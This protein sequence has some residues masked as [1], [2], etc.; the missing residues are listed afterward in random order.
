MEFTDGYVR[1]LKPQAQRYSEWDTAGDPRGLGV[2]VTPN[3]VKSYVLQAMTRPGG[4]Q[5]L[6]TLGR[7]GSMRLPAARKA[8]WAALEQLQAGKDP[9]REKQT[10]GA[11]TFGALAEMYIADEL[12][13][14]RQG[15]TVETY[16]RRDWLGETPFRARVTTHG[17][18]EWITEWKPGRDRQFSDLP[19]ASITREDILDRLNVIRRERG[20]YAARHALAAIRQVLNWAAA[21]YRAGV[22]VSPAAGLR[23]RVV[24]L[25]GAALMR[26]RVLTADEIRAIW[27]ACPRMGSFGVLVR[28]LLLTCARRDDWAAASWK[29]LSG[30]EG[31][32][33]MLTVPPARYKTAQTHEVM[34]TP[35][36]VSALAELPRFQGCDWLFS[37]DGKRPLQ[38]FS[39]S[40]RRL[41]EASGVTGWR[42]HDLRRTGR[43][44]MANIGV[45]DAAAE[46]VLGHSLGSLNATYNMSKH[47]A[48]K[49]AA[50][51]ALEAEI[52]RIV[53]P[54]AVAMR[55]AA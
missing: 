38:S 4:R 9:N 34:L 21:T 11:S 13:G 36:V 55:V 46:R 53:A 3:G 20:K 26:H 32:D 23:D 30:L 2:R 22:R 6:V 27:A 17:K 5:V 47:R 19:A 49:R 35:A 39:A 50:L 44:L 51:A 1:S 54:T 10:A 43:T 42:L 24:G 31:P 8:A 14:K 29:E 37:N 28:V 52:L 41:D 33:A 7:V 12:A 40:K 18:T 25:T 16:L 15:R 45:D 48:Q